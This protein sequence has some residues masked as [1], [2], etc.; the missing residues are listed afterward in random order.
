MRE[1]RR[2]PDGRWYILEGSEA[3]CRIG[4]PDWGPDPRGYWPR[5]DLEARALEETLACP[6]CGTEWVLEQFDCVFGTACRE[7]N[8]IRVLVRCTTCRLPHRVRGVGFATAYP[9]L[10]DLM[11]G[12]TRHERRNELFRAAEKS[13]YGDEPAYPDTR[14][15][16]EDV[17]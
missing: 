13:F 7:G 14:R 4:P 3:L 2:S 12:W 11:G 5:V 17:S 8:D 1:A 15:P 16:Q 9:G 10:M 6:N